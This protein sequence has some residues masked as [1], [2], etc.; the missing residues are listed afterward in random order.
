[1]ICY[2]TSV[3]KKIFSLPAIQ[4]KVHKFFDKIIDLV[5]KLIKNIDKFN[6]NLIYRFF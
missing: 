3:G 6:Y 5:D 2:K 1:M 4:R